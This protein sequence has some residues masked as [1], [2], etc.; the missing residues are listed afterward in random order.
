MQDDKDCISV[1]IPVYNTA[2]YLPQCLDSVLA[3]S[4]KNLQI[5]CVNDGSRDKSGSVLDA[6]AKK[7]KRIEVIHKENGGVSSARNAA[8]SRVNG[9]YIHFLDSDDWID[10]GLYKTALKHF[11]NL[12]IDIYSF[13]IYLENGGRE[14]SMFQKNLLPGLY[15]RINFLK[16]LCGIKSLNNRV[17]TVY[18][19]SPSKIYKSSLLRNEIKFNEKMRYL[20]DGEFLTRLIPAVNSVYIDGRGFYHRRMHSQSAMGSPDSGT[21]A[22]N[23]LEGYLE[24][25]GSAICRENI[26]ARQYIHAASERAG[27]HYLQ[28]CVEDGL[29]HMKQEIEALLSDIPTFK[30]KAEE[31]L[32]NFIAD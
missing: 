19:S 25:R 16:L 9:N 13:N 28:R 12:G 1:V 14:V 30:N 5:I 8:L 23:M 10:S 26:V 21:L 11:K 29:P 4:F 18:F 24:L 17:S 6:Y 31:M 2:K 32:A 22:R 27:L 20:E 3:Q 15:N 7:D